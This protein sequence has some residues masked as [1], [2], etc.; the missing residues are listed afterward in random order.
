MLYGEKKSKEKPS[1][2]Y[3][4]FMT[5][6]VYKLLTNTEKLLR[7]NNKYHT[8]LTSIQQLSNRYSSK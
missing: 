3:V 7:S 5:K 1:V 2:A 6:S 4:L 8:E